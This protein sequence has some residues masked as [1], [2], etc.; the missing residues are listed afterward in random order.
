M[1]TGNKNINFSLSEPNYIYDSWYKEI[2]KFMKN[3]KGETNMNQ[4]RSV[5]NIAKTIFVILTAVI[6]TYVNKVNTSYQYSADSDEL[7]LPKCFD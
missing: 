1:E 4:S 2:M 6:P 7:K 5:V 3:M